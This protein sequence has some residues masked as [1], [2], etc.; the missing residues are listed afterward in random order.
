[1]PSSPTF[2]IWTMAR[3][4]LAV[5]LSLALLLPELSLPAAARPLEA[6]KARGLLSLCAHPNALPFSRRSQEPHGF[7]I[8]LAGHLAAALGVA[9][10]IDWITS[11]FQIRR[12][13][14][15][16]LLDSIN[17]KEAQ[18]DRGLRLSRPYQTSGVALAFR[19]DGAKIAGFADLEATQRLGVLFGSL[20]S[21]L[22]GQR[23]LQTIPFGFEDEMMTAL[24]DG[25]ID[26]AAVSP[27]TAGYFIKSEQANGTTDKV[28]DLVHAY[29]AEQDL[30]W[31]LAVGMRRADP[32]FRRAINKALEDL[33]ADGTMAAIYARY[34][35]EH[36]PPKGR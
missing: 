7:Q 21:V 4:G 13:D 11:G 5:A 28:Y 19:A 32:P 23:G 6:I 10:D 29:D 20:A 31:T 9:L 35:I 22:L 8:E 15:D 1:M 18:A 36:R 30:R 25:E 16:I 27:M 34:G 2:A 3:L 14:C 26:V 24:L 17:D 33:H 12:A